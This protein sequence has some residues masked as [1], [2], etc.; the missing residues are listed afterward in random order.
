[1]P[2]C[3]DDDYDNCGPDT[4]GGYCLGHKPDK[5]EAEIERFYEYISRKLNEEEESV[6]RFDGYIFP[7]KDSSSDSHGN[8]SLP[9]EWAGNDLS[10]KEVTFYPSFRNFNI[11]ISDYIQLNHSEFKSSV[12][13]NLSTFKYGGEFIDVRFED[14]V[15]FYQVDFGRDQVFFDDSRFFGEV[16]FSNSEFNRASF[17]N[18][19]FCQ[20]A[21]FN[22][23]SFHDEAVFH[24][25]EFHSGVSFRAVDFF[26][27]LKFESSGENLSRKYRTTESDIEASR[28][29]KKYFDNEGDKFLADK[30]FVREMKARQKQDLKKGD[31][32][33]KLWAIIQKVLAE[34]TTDYGT[35]PYKLLI[36]VISIITVSSILY[37]TSSLYFP[38]TIGAICSS[39]GFVT[40]LGDIFYFSAVTFTTLG[41]GDLYPTGYLKLVSVLEALLGALFIALTIAVFSRKWMRS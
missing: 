14:N 20:E 16:T 19:C 1:M 36:W 23:T 34:W 5:D 4:E 9:N 21:D 15:S 33:D 22:G 2:D 17:D 6:V 41:Y 12:S 10:F 11:D 32:K 3:V 39:D 35:N 8:F 37:G 26:H 28:V 31:L 38:Q 13:F 40:N 18:V 27:D 24:K 29:Q 30:Y 7:P 25:A